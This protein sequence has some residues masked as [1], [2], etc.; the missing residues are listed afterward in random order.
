MAE[1]WDDY[2]PIHD[3]LRDHVEYYNAEAKACERLKQRW[4]MLAQG[5]Y[6]VFLDNEEGQAQPPVE[7]KAEI[8]S[9][10]KAE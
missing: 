2:V 8:T 9:E 1:M 5:Y 7:A 3:V 10:N 4:G 6:L